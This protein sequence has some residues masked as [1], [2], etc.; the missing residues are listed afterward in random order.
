MINPC[1]QLFAHEIGK[2]HM[3]KSRDRGNKEVRKPKAPKA[4]K[5]PATSSFASPS[6]APK[7]GKSSNKG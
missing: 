4:E 1:E 7:P 6:A 2:Q 3:A 5:A